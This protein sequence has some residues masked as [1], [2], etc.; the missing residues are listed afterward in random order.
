MKP[1][2]AGL[3]FGLFTVFA[4]RGNLQ[5]P[6][7]PQQ[8]KSWHA[9]ASVPTNILSAVETLFAQGFPDPR[10]CEYREIEVEVSG[11]WDGKS[12]LIKTHGWVLP[13]KSGT[14]HFAIC[15]NGLVYPI[16]KISAPASLHA[17]ITNTV[18]LPGMR[19][20]WDWQHSSAAGE[21]Q[22]IFFTGA[23]TTRL[24]LLLR[25]GEIAAAL[26]TWTPFLP[27]YRFSDGSERV[28]NT[29][30]NLID[31]YLEFAS[32]WTWALFDRIICAHMR[33]DEALALATARQLAEVQPKIEAEAA[34]RGFHRQQY[35]DS[36]RQGKEKP[37]LEF[38]E[39]LP[40]LLADLERREKKGPRVSV[41]QSGLQN[42]TNQMERI[43]ALIR[44]LDLVQ[45]HQ[46]GQPGGIN[47]AEG[48]A[49][50]ALI[51]EGDAAVEPLLDCLDNDKRL[52]RSVG[53]GRDFFRGRT[54]IPVN[55]AAGTALQAILHAGFGGKVS[56]IRA[57]WD[58]Y[59]NL[60][61]E[62]RWYAILNDDA[63]NS[64]WLEA[65]G[66]I[67]QP[68]NIATYP[69]GFS[70]VKPAPTNAPV[71]LRGEI[72]RSKSNPSLSELMARRA[73]EV[74][75]ENPNAYDISSACQMG[76]HLAVW[77]KQAAGP[78]VKTLA[79]RCRTVMEYSGQQLGGLL[80][81]L[82]LA[83]AQAGDADAFEEYAAWLPT[84]SPEQM[85]FSILECLEPLKQFPTN[86]SLESAAE[87]MF[88]GTN[89]AW[90]RLPWPQTGS[91][92]PAS[93][94]LVKVPAFRRLLVRELYRK[95]VRGSVSWQASGMVN[96]SMSNYMSG[97]FS[98]A[99]P[100][101]SQITNGTSAELRW[102]DWIALSLANGKHIPPFNPF[103]PVEKRDDSIE[104]AKKIL[105]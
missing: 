98:Y 64:R 35:Y 39:Q 51:Q 22:T 102:C 57:Y 1:L 21:Q 94:A 71:R 101:S 25:S 33:G 19:P 69:Y 95:E 96:Y 104:A 27:R 12:S 60:K 32:D 83:R 68:E 82:S 45:A 13:K 73:L 38:L 3:V 74:P 8:H 80:T 20:G 100:E 53:F 24:L 37:Y 59:K 36:P 88:A 41:I 63:A 16:A 84:T 42:I 23:G 99:F 43:A 18:R 48:S 75:K 34:K 31:P 55:S 77:D 62:H 17:E 11:V 93:S 78:V 52:T 65:A 29:N 103:A 86:T 61:L 67:V 49:V 50:A 9:D 15:W 5:L 105:R 54:V 92:S 70:V 26:K 6:E 72:L 76:L 40:Q 14:N 58:K 85:G 10:G 89:S 46:W 47:L 56:E 87:K 91:E 90:G 81:K 2:F 30:V 4:C 79:K 97:S 7:P 66:N 44:D 28:I